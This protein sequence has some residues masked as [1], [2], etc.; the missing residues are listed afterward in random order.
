MKIITYEKKIHL[1]EKLNNNKIIKVIIKKNKKIFKYKKFIF[2]IL[3][4]KLKNK[5]F[6][7]IKKLN[8]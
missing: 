4:F 2:Q 7:I 5:Y 8:S 3:N 6:K 1:T